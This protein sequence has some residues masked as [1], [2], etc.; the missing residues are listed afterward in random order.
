MQ[1]QVRTPLLLALLCTAVGGCSSGAGVGGGG[2]TSTVSTTSS[3]AS[4]ATSGSAIGGGPLSSSSAGGA[5][6][7]AGEASTS[8]GATTNSASVGSSSAGADGAGAG[9]GPAGG[10]GTG[11]TAGSMGT[12]GSFVSGLCGNCPAGTKPASDVRCV[13]NDNPAYGCAGPAAVPCSG[14]H[15]TAWSCDAGACS[16]AACESGWGDCNGDPS[17]GCE[18]DLTSA[19][20]CGD[21]ARACA[22]GE[23]CTPTGCAPG[24]TP[25]L[26]DCNSSCADLLSSAEHCGDCAN[27]CPTDGVGTATCTNGA[28]ALQ[29]PVGFILNAG[30]CVDPDSDPSCCG[31][32]CEFCS[33]TAGEPAC[34]GGLCSA[35]CWP[36]YTACLLPPNPAGAAPPI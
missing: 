4:G 30:R 15:A 21:C 10:G 32:A 19:L 29:C 3:D 27:P 13:P 8:S 14:P 2:A 28:C 6:A 26:T 31:A 9:G 22:V 18:S 1:A 25:P 20:T 7:S 35:Y 36:G 17:D 11:G 5:S 34:I 24:C 33:V 16:P 23:A 12:G